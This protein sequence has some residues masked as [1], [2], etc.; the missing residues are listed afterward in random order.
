MQEI[1]SQ[2]SDDQEVVIRA[3]E[4][5]EARCKRK[6]LLRRQISLESPQEAPVPVP[7]PQKSPE[8]SPDDAVA[9]PPSIIEGDDPQDSGDLQ[10]L[11]DSDDY[12]EAEVST[13]DT[14]PHNEQGQ[15]P[16]GDGAGRRPEDEAIFD[17][18]NLDIE[19]PVVSDIAFQY[20]FSLHI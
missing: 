9:G 4:R 12:E 15:A 8:D 16:D 6:A 14:L 10:P 11:P 17:L 19:D 2:S 1:E 7:S 13:Q 3:R 5:Q 20:K 18:S